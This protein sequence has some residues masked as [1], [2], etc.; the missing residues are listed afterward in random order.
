ME[1]GKTAE[2][3]EATCIRCEEMFCETEEERKS[4]ICGFCTTPEDVEW[5]PIG[6]RLP[7]IGSLFPPNEN[8]GGTKTQKGF[9]IYN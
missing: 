4:H 5:H 8:R 7:K 2:E 6:N 9:L 1:Q 3:Y